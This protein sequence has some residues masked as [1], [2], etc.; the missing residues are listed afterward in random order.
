MPQFTAI[1]RD[2]HAGKKWQRVQELR[3]CFDKRLGADRRR[4]DCPGGTLSMPLAFFQDRGRFV[5]VAVLS[6][7]ARPQHAGSA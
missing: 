6:L 7:S 5:L 3:F 1:S 2:S 4:G